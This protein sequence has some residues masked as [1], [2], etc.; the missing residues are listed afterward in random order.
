[1]IKLK[2]SSIGIKQCL[3]YG[4]ILFIT[5]LL[6]HYPL[7][8][9]EIPKAAY[10]RLKL[11]SAYASA[12]TSSNPI[13]KDKEKYNGSAFSGGPF[14]SGVFS[15]SLHFSLGVSYAEKKE[16]EQHF[17]RGSID[18]N[19]SS[20]IYSLTAS[21]Y[22]YDDTYFA[23]EY[24]DASGLYYS[25]KI[26]NGRQQSFVGNGYGIKLGRDWWL[27]NI[28]GIGFAFFYSSE[29]LYLGKGKINYT[30]FFPK[31]VQAIG[32]NIDILYDW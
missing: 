22:F 18:H 10:F 30:S 1:M 24:R 28:Y 12:S 15:E 3:P 6:C 23:I 8:A 5:F 32:F 2:L 4:L 29:H 27:S 25:N 11:E 9:R 13:W 31:Y 7:S 21:Y 26:G 16:R 14:I 19:Y 20:L 17:S